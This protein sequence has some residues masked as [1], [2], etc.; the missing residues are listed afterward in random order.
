MIKYDPLQYKSPQRKWDATNKKFVDLWRYE[1]VFEVQLYDERKIKVQ[2]VFEYDKG[3]VPKF[4][5]NWLPRDD[6]Q[7]V[8]AFLIH[9]WLHKT[10]KI[11]D[12]WITRREA[13]QIFY[14]LLRHAGMRWTKA[15]IAQVAVRI[16]GSRSWNKQAK[17]LGNTHA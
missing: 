9:D 15:Q 5:Q 4:M 2:P 6:K 16:G 7:A 8:I 13:D 11:E 12:Q 14:D 3:S 17:K 10:Q 1:A